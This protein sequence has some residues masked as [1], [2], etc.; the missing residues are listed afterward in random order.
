MRGSLVCVSKKPKDQGPFKA[1]GQPS[2]VL[3][4]SVPGE[5]LM[6]PGTLP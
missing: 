3:R 1:L 6:E 4:T 5:A 2:A